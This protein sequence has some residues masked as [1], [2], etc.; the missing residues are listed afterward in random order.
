[1]SALCQKWTS[2]ELLDHVVG[3]GEQRWRDRET[4]GLCCLAIDYK[5]VLG[6][7]LHRQ[8]GRLLT[9]EDSVDIAG[10]ASV[11]IDKVRPVGHQAAGVHKE[12]I[13]KNGRQFVLRREADDQ[14]ALD[15]CD[16]ADDHYQSVV[17]CRRELGYSTLS[18]T[19]YLQIDRA[20]LHT[21]WLRDGPD[22]RPLREASRP[23]CFP[24][25]PDTDDVRRDLL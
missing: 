24:D 12:A 4:E 7:C 8:V 25:D 15:R 18:V 11:E 13:G 19:C 23:D 21:K 6:R 20:E 2:A 17:W 3:A 5:L 14:I 22:H 10:R 1:M 16:S 9:L